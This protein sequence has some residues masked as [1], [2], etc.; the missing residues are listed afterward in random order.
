MRERIDELTPLRT[1]D[2]NDNFL[3]GKRPVLLGKHLKG[4]FSAYWL[5]TNRAEGRLGD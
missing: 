1:A 4:H 3:R 5:L 2:V